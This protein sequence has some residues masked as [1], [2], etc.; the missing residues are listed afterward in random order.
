MNP[1]PLP[2]ALLV[3]SV[4]AFALPPTARGQAVATAPAKPAVVTPGDNLVIEGI[5]DLPA[6]LADGQ[7]LYRVSLGE[8]R[9]LASHEARDAHRHALRRHAAGPPGAPRRAAR[10]AA[11]V[12]PRPRRRRDWP[13]RRATTSSSP[14]T[15]AATSSSRSTV[16]TSPPASHA[17]HRRRPR[18]TPGPWSHAG[19]RMAYGSTRRTGADV[20]FYVVDPPDPRT[21]SRVLENKGGGWGVADWSPDDKQ[22]LVVEYVSINES[23]IWL[24]DV[25]TGKKT[26][27]RP[28]AARR[29][30]T[31]RCE[32]RRQGHLR[33]DRPG[34]EFM[35]LAYIDLA[36]KKHTSLTTTF[37]GTSRLRR[38]RTTAS[39][40]PSSPTKT[41]QRPA[42]ARHA[43]RQGD[44]RAEAAGGHDRRSG[45][46]R[47]QSRPGLR[48]HLGPLAGR[49]LL[50]RRHHRQD[51]PLDGERIGRSRTRRHSPSRS[52]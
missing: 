31:S 8:P 46:A 10:D 19:D 32:R 30:P 29:S 9:R 28:G 40:S 20:D 34:R 21:T 18:A 44:A 17:A 43:H 15:R 11:H 2:S 49:R 42:P 12:L 7:P 13:R 39:R 4:L 5:P 37:P 22:L 1:R 48:G 50:A 23:Y 45:M 25:A 41:A 14:R 24:V 16:T 26:R 33:R 52:W 6:E 36:S 35:R 38:C 3:A 27:S 51:R 47:Q